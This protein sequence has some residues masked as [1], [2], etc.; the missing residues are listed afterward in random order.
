MKTDLIYDVGLHKGEDSEFYLRKGFRVVAIEALPDYCE[1]AR[2]RLRPYVESGQL[3]IVNAAIAE[4][5]GPVPFF[6]NTDNSVWGTTSPEWAKRNERLGRRSFETTVNGVDFGA[7]LET[8]GVPYFLKIDIEGAD[9]LCLKALRSCTSRPKYLSVESNKTSWEGL[10]R[11]FEVLRELGYS[12]FKVVQQETV[13]SQVCPFPAK[14]GSYV[15]HHFN[16]DASGLFGEEAPGHWLS[17]SEAL[18]IYRG[19]FLRYKLVGDDALLRR[20]LRPLIGYGKSPDNRIGVESSR[21]C[22][23]VGVH[24]T[25][26]SNAQEHFVR[27][28]LKPRV[29]WYDTHAR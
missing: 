16:A 7:I 3:V 11:E 6:V 5:S 2:Q 15:D 10:R 4:R 21:E 1:I 9:M 17:E 26:S 14:E 22:D 29:G 27:N 24:R 20:L 25:G 23:D 8:F 13:D 19:I 28:L 12:R 18:R